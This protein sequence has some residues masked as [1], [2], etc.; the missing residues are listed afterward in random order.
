LIDRVNPL[1]NIF[2]VKYLTSKNFT[3]KYFKWNNPAASRI[4][5]KHTK[6]IN[7]NFS[8]GSEELKHHPICGATIDN[9]HQGGIKTMIDKRLSKKAKYDIWKTDDYI[10][11]R[12][13]NYLNDGGTMN[14]D[15][16]KDLYFGDWYQEEQAAAAGKKRYAKSS[17]ERPYLN[18]EGMEDMLKILHENNP[19]LSWDQFLDSYEQGEL[20]IK[21]YVGGGLVGEHNSQTG[22]RIL[23]KFS[24]MQISKLFSFINK[25]LKNV[26]QK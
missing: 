3:Q 25:E 12:Y 26:Q 5:H 8:D 7:I 1:K 20:D 10:L 13:K 19:E 14:L 17:K 18:V 4:S 24:P 11:Y 2:K 22:K 15:E 21:E 6:I 23:D 9:V 16:F